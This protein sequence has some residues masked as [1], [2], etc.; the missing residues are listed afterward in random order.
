M[1][2]DARPANLLLVHSRRGPDLI[3][4]SSL[5]VVHEA[6]NARLV[7]NE[8]ACLDTRD[9]LLHVTLWARERLECKRRTDA[10]LRLDLSLDV[11]ILEGE[12]A[13]VSVLDETDLLR[14]KKAL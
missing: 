9:R 5:N 2:S 4:T 6:S 13:A 3:Q 14:A 12:H 11:V 1:A 8:W 7:R 10:N